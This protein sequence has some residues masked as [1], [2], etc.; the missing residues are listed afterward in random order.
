M[1]AELLLEISAAGQ[2]PGRHELVLAVRNVSARRLLIP[3]PDIIGFCFRRLDDGTEAQWETRTLQ[4][5]RWRG[6]VLDAGA[7]E[8]TAFSIVAWDARTAAEK[9]PMH[10]DFKR[11]GLDLHAGTYEV[12]YRL[13]VDDAYF[14]PDTHCR[15]ADLVREAAARGADA[16]RGDVTSN[17][18]RVAHR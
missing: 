14:D 4:S 5:G 11:W 16:W 1:D 10:P 9:E 17:V 7:G 6:V 15:L 13:Q 8:T 12:T 18:L 2:T 3:A